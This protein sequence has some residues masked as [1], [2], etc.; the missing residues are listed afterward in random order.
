MCLIKSLRKYFHDIF[1]SFSLVPSEI[2]S[3]VRGK[4]VVF[5][6]W[7]EIVEHLVIPE[8]V[9]R[10]CEK[11]FLCRQ[12]Q[13]HLLFY[14]VF[15]ISPRGFPWFEYCNKQKWIRLFSF[16]INLKIQCNTSTITYIPSRLFDFIK[17]CRVTIKHKYIHFIICTWFL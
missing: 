10:L 11:T 15:P 12:L 13:V 1:K 5:F 6:L 9:R 8:I 4:N 16:N 2:D 3:I 14:F 7:N 17:L